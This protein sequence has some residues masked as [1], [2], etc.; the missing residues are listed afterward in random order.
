MV[1]NSSFFLGVNISNEVVKNSL[2]LRYWVI[3][4]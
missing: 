1:L 2:D 4:A 3:I